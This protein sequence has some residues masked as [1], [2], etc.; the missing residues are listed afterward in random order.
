MIVGHFCKLLGGPAGTQPTKE[1]ELAFEVE[2]SSEKAQID[3]TTRRNKKSKSYISGLMDHT[4]TFN[5]K[6]E[7]DDEGF[8]LLRNAYYA[9]TPIALFA[10]DEEGNGVDGDW[11]IFSFNRTEP[12]EDTVQYAV[13]CKPAFLPGTSG[14][15]PA[16]V[17]KAS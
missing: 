3:A 13:T 7:V 9:G 17:D 14:R 10:S 12:E 4:L 16:W 8:E 5:Y 6:Y 11:E 15:E 2:I 1:L